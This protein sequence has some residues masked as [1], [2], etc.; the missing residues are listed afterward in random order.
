MKNIYFL[1]PCCLFLIVFD[2]YINIYCICVFNRLILLLMSKVPALRHIETIDIK[3]GINTN[4]QQIVSI[5]EEENLGILPMLPELLDSNNPL[6]DATFWKF[7]KQ[8]TYDEEKIMKQEP[9]PEIVKSE[10]ETAVEPPKEEIK[11]E[12]IKKDEPIIPEQPIENKD[13]SKPLEENP[14]KEEIHLLNEMVESTNDE[15]QKDPLTLSLRQLDFI[16]EETD[17]KQEE[18]IEDKLKEEENPS[19]KEEDNKNQKEEEIPSP[20]EE[21]IPSPKEEKISLLKEEISSP[22]EEEVIEEKEKSIDNKS[23]EESEPKE[24]TNPNIENKDTLENQQSSDVKE[25]VIIKENNDIPKKTL[26]EIFNDKETKTEDTKK[27]DIKIPSK[28][29]IDTTQPDKALEE[30]REANINNATEEAKKSCN[31]CIIF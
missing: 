16:E 19:P 29:D 26:T 31:C 4:I 22:K 9:I 14:I 30:L 2:I 13:N 3:Q 8:A 15:F 24:E 27:N 1:L 10:Q 21:E 25:E 18:L 6:P 5:H 23:K 11:V 7:L 20:K 12:E 28:I 17:N